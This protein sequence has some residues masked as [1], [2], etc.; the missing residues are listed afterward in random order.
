MKESTNQ[1]VFET[2]RLLVRHFSVVDG[3]NFF[4][5]NGNL[6]VMRYIRPVKS[7]EE[8]DLFLT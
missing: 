6:E 3:D 2:E 1:V 5:L 7:R 4:L 8:T